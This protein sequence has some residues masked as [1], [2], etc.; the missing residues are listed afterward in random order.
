MK[1]HHRLFPAFLLAGLLF[2]GVAWA[3][4]GS[5]SLPLQSQG[6]KAGS[7]FTQPWQPRL[8]SEATT[9][10]SQPENRQ[11]SHPSKMDGAGSNFRKNSLSNEPKPAADGTSPEYGVPQK[12]FKGLTVGDIGPHLS[13]GPPQS[14]SSTSCF[15]GLLMKS[16]KDEGK[17]RKARRE[18]IEESEKDKKKKLMGDHLQH[19]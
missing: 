13:S 8:D 2:A 15:D 3:Q 16:L 1:C 5:D 10:F 7:K 18:K 17:P 9:V 19:D 14:A 6:N 12:P 4:K 11:A